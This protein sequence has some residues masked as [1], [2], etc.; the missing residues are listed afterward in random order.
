MSK[1]DKTN[2]ALIGFMGTGKSSVSHALCK[3]L[4]MSE[5]DMDE[6]IVKE[7]GLA[8]SAIFEK[9]GEEYFREAEAQLLQRLA[10]GQDCVISCGGGTVTREKN[11]C[12][13]RE[14]AYIVLL[15]ASPQT[16][17]SRVKNST[18]RPVLNGNMTVEYIEALM[19]KRETAYK[20]AA[21]I[22]VSTD[23]KSIKQICSEIIE[24]LK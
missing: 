20:K 7:Q 4:D 12:L 15:T 5:I 2:I 10:E 17:Y 19:Q 13:L 14:F 6:I 24:E 16:V 9:Y 8:I 1:N 11:V 22:T 3:K 18:A 21:D 23:G